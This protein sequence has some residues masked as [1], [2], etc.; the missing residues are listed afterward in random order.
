[1]TA[2]FRAQGMKMQRTLTA[3]CLALVALLALSVAPT[4]A[5][6][7]QGAD[8]REPSIP[9]LT[10]DNVEYV[11]YMPTDVPAISGALREVG[12][13]RLFYVWSI[14][15]L[16][17]YNV[18]APDLPKLVGFLPLPA[19]QGEDMQVSADGTR[20]IVVADG[21]S[22]TPVPA[23][24]GLHVIDTTN[25]ASPVKEA[26]LTTGANH[27]AQCA[28]DA[29]QWL[30]GDR[31][32]IY[33]IPRT[34][35]APTDIKVVGSWLSVA[36]AG[37]NTVNGVHALNRSTHADGTQIM[38]SDSTPRV[39][40]NVTDPAKPVV[41]ARSRNGD[42]VAVDGIL[43]H[44]NV[45]PHPELWQPRAAD[46]PGPTYSAANGLQSIPGQLRPGELIISGSEKNQTVQCPEAGGKVVAWSIAN[47]D[48]GAAPRPLSALKLESSNTFDNGNPPAN[49]QGCSSHW[50]DWLDDPAPSAPDGKYLL[51][52]GWY[53]HGVRVISVDPVDY[54]LKIVGFAQLAMGSAAAAY[55][56]PAAKGTTDGS[57][58]IYAPDYRR[59]LHVLRYRP[60]P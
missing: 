33:N 9:L 16:S 52:A 7:D 14:K 27:A 49:V 42:H 59:G 36:R 22:S 50:F 10:S 39:I 48:R 11:G 18:D 4:G 6:P 26:T 1:M 54:S 34:I 30:Y 41:M 55:W 21:S 17:I 44:N 40:M 45:R 8:I 58:Y 5:V 60:G 38:I 23:N 13:Q 3:A 12:G 56:V 19:S 29:C 37:G 53:E 24:T 15:G 35:T 2:Q 57:V 47:F 46:D 28:D 31:G 32:S 20:T 25:P 43:Q 51:A